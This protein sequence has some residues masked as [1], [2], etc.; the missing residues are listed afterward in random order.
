VPRVGDVDFTVDRLV[1]RANGDLAG[2][3]GNLVHRVVTMVHRY[4]GGRPPTGAARAERLADACA[5][6]PHRIDAA[7]EAF[8]FR[9]AVAAVWAIVEE[10][11]RYIEQVRPWHLST[12]DR[13]A[14]LAV[15]LDACR[16]LG[17]H[18]GPFL[19][20]TAARIVDRCTP[21]DGRLPAPRP[22]FPR[23]LTATPETVA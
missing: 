23:I 21:S 7:L 8:D 19:P 10:A 2:G 1:A 4:R 14:A 13:D 15:L 5:Q 12:E 6:A 22:L 20:D 18:L 11:N 16:A 17:E 3:L 9:A